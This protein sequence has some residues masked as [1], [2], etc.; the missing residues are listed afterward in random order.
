MFCFKKSSVFQ[1]RRK[2][3]PHF[4]AA[5]SPVTCVVNNLYQ[6]LVSMTVTDFPYFRVQMICFRPAG[7]LARHSSC[8]PVLLSA[9]CINFRHL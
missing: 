1:P 4:P 5:F 2:L 3:C 7:K 8:G 9:F 6:K